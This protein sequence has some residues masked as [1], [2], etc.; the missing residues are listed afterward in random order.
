M[1][2]IKPLIRPHYSNNTFVGFT[3]WVFNQH[4][5]D[6]EPVGAPFAQ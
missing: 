1:N 6:Y 4:M 2:N 5:A 3:I